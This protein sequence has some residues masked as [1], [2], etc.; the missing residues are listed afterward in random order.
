MHRNPEK[1]SKHWRHSVVQVRSFY[2]LIV[3]LFPRVEKS[4]FKSFGFSTRGERDT[5]FTMLTVPSETTSARASRNT[6]LDWPRPGPKNQP[7]SSSFKSQLTAF[8]QNHQESQL[9][10]SGHDVINI[11]SQIS[12]LGFLLWHLYEH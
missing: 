3:S 9:I 2:Y 5:I 12:Y 8:F 7:A 1:H 10:A 11:P 6:Q 4:K